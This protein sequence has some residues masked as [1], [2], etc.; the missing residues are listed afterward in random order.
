[1]S[2]D[3]T[4]SPVNLGKVLADQMAVELYRDFQRNLLN[5]SAGQQDCFVEIVSAFIRRQAPVSE[6][7]AP[8]QI[9]T[10]EPEPGRI[11]DL[12]NA[13][14]HARYWTDGAKDCD[15]REE[16]LIALHQ[17]VLTWK[18]AAYHMAD[19]RD[20]AKR[21]ACTAE[22]RTTCSFAVSATVT[23]TRSTRDHA[24]EQFVRTIAGPAFGREDLRAEAKHI[25][26]AQ[27]VYAFGE[28]P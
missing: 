26:N 21:Q 11:P 27:G 18:N 3:A 22:H 4:H 8:A 19:Q 1:M 7:A 24:I 28:K 10:T 2:S 14:R 16:A 9:T 13:E 20:A 15:D 17:A 23:P 5:S 12:H 6:T 25:L